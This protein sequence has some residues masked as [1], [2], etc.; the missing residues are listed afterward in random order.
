M[1]RSSLTDTCLQAYMI[2]NVSALGFQNTN[3]DTGS[4]TFTKLKAPSILVVS[5]SL[6][7][8]HRTP[9]NAFPTFRSMHTQNT[10]SERTFQ[11]ELETVLKRS[12]L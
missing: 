8:H 12:L 2:P 11:I 6:L 3:Q 5:A 4:L 1:A 9:D 7:C 10:C